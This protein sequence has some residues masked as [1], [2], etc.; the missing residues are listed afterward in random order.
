M[1]APMLRKSGRAGNVMTG[2]RQA[3]SAGVAD[4][5]RSWHGCCNS[6]LPMCRYSE[7]SVF[8]AAWP[9]QSYSPQI[10]MPMPVQHC[11]VSTAHCADAGLRCATHHPP[12]PQD[13][14][15]RHPGLHPV[16]DQICHV[17]DLLCKAAR[18]VDE[19]HGVSGQAD[20]RHVRARLPVVGD[21]L[22]RDQ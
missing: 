13:H 16:L 15:V 22:H 4:V 2:G 9:C 8:R 7:H 18:A 12:V 3:N 1:C 21:T 10:L 5:L 11:W 20:A 6:P 17:A 14:K 19:G